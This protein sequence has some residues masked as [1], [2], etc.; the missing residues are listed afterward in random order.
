GTQAAISFSSGYAAAV[1]TIGALM[2]SNDVIVVDK[3][4]HASVVDAARLCGA[5]LRVFGHNNLDDL[6]KILQ[7]VDK[8]NQNGVLSNDSRKPRTL[9]VTESVFSMDGDQAPLRE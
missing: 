2:D 1:R 5:K 7:W 6:K 3:L 9:I 4:V 8:R